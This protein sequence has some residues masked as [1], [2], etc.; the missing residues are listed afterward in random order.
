LFYTP[1]T[2]IHFFET[3]S[4]S[5]DA[6]LATQL[7]VMITSANEKSIVFHDINSTKFQRASNKWP[8][9]DLPSITLPFSD[10]FDSVLCCS[11]ME[12]L[13]NGQTQLILGT[14]GKKIL[15]YNFGMWKRIKFVDFRRYLS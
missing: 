8:H 7:N 2:S 9:P 11:T 14:F 3:P 15:V 4:N 13:L 12:M 5:S 10:C 6:V 1:V